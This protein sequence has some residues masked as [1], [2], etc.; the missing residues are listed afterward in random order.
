MNNNHI[1]GG[2]LLAALIIGY[3]G[4]WA[5]NLRRAQTAN[6]DRENLK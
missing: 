3:L 2:L 5:H 6:R 1:L 4:V